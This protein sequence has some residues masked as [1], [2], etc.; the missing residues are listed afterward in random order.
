LYEI[1]SLFIWGSSLSLEWDGS[2]FPKALAEAQEK[3][4]PLIDLNTAFIQEAWQD[5]TV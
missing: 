3:A 4:R 2:L 1:P 5:I